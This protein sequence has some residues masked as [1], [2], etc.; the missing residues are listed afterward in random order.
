VQVFTLL[1]LPDTKHQ[2]LEVIIN[3][4]WAKHWLWRRVYQRTQHQDAALSNH[5]SAAAADAGAS[6][7]SALQEQASLQFAAVD[8]AV[9]VAGGAA[10]EQL[11]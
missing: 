7:G 3:Q 6:A 11:Q 4:C 1:L 5:S 9:V 10:T 2:Q 8:A